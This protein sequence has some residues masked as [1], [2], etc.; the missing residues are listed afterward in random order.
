MSKFDGDDMTD[1]IKHYKICEII[2]T[3]NDITETNEWVRQFLAT[4]RGVA[5][6][7]FAD[8][9]P[10]KLTNWVGVKKEFIIKFQLLLDDNE[11]IAEIYNT[12]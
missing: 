7:W 3:E 11:I 4:L 12:K 9:D 2:W 5:I 6:D 10:Q 8:A 1:P